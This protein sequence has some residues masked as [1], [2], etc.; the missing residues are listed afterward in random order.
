MGVGLGTAAKAGGS[1]TPDPKG[2][3]PPPYPTPLRAGSSMYG[4]GDFDGLRFRPSAGEFRR[5]GGRAS[6]PNLSHWRLARGGSVPI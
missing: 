4:H 2:T 1:N 3:A 6:L 5:Y